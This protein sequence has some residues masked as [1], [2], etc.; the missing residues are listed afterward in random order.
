MIHKLPQELNRR[1]CSI[2][3][4]AR[5]VQV[6]QKYSTPLAWSRTNHP[7][8]SLL[9]LRQEDLTRLHS[10][11]LCTEC[12]L[13]GASCLS[14]SCPEELLNAH[15][16]AGAG[17]PDQENRSLVGQAELQHLARLQALSSRHDDLV[18]W[19]CLIKLRITLHLIPLDLF[20]ITCPSNYRATSLSSYNPSQYY[21]PLL[22]AS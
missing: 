14:W 9:E 13:D 21:C 10:C 3:L 5:H 12:N 22:F 11:R 19:Y 15:R 16:L 4:E 17:R 2:L 20:F 7:S 8:S 6:I 18:V 1:L